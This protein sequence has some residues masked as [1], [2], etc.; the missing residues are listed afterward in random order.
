MKVKNI[1]TTLAAALVGLAAVCSCDNYL[2]IDDDRDDCGYDFNITYRVN[3][4]TN[5]DEEISNK[6]YA[7]ADAYVRAALQK[8]WDNIFRAYSKDLNLSFFKQTEDYL[9]KQETYNDFDSNE[10]SYTIFLDYKKYRHLALGNTGQEEAVTTN[11]AEKSTAAQLVA[12]GS[13]SMENQHVGLFTGRADLEAGVTKDNNYL[14]NLYQANSSAALVLDTIDAQISGVRM[15]LEDMASVFN[16]SDSTYS[17][18]NGAIVAGRQ[19]DISATENH[20][21]CYYAVCFPSRDTATSDD[22]A[23]WR[24]NVYVELPDGTTTKNELKVYSRLRAGYVKIIKAKVYPN[25]ALEITDAEVGASVMLDWK[26]G[27]SYN[28]DL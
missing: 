17:Y 21:L 8:E 23:V 13:K 9:D 5:K 26:E 28:P 19:L 24:M 22:K 7:P 14:V 18:T 27:G 15:E 20:R 11:L 16:I 6:L 12:K 2:G 3:L 10:K 1:F 4:N 25:G